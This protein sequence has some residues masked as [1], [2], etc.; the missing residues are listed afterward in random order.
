[1]GGLHDGIQCSAFSRSRFKI[2]RVFVRLSWASQMTYWIFAGQSRSSSRYGRLCLSFWLIQVRPQLLYRSQPDFLLERSKRSIWVGNES[3]S[4][5]S[6]V[7]SQSFLFFF[8]FFLGYLYHFYMSMIAAFCTNS[9]NVRH[10]AITD[11]SSSSLAAVPFSASTDSRRYQRTRSGPV[12]GDFACSADAQLAAAGR[13]LSFGSYHFLRWF[14][15]FLSFFLFIYI[16]IFSHIFL[17]VN[18]VVLNKASDIMSI[19]LM[20]PFMAVTL[21]LLVFNWYP[22]KVFVGDTYTYFAGRN[23]LYRIG[24]ISDHSFLSSQG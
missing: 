23:I 15:F 7:C 12:F 4:R 16:Y 22:S 1:M 2:I 9:I 19:F 21:G 3:G 17:S 24:K 8:F 10:N 6:L 13:T 20:M 11:V 18:R 5:I 14:F